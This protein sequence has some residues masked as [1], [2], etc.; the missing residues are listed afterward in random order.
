MCVKVFLLLVLV[1]DWTQC[2]P[3]GVSTPPAMQR[4]RT[5][6]FPKNGWPGLRRG[7]IDWYNLHSPPPDCGAPTTCRLYP[8]GAANW[9]QLIHPGPSSSRSS[10]F[11]ESSPLYVATLTHYSTEPLT[12]GSDYDPLLLLLAVAA[13][14]C[15]R[16][17]ERQGTPA[18]K[19]H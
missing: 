5:A 8:F 9:S 15:T 3:Q 2:L 17:Q 7:G 19:R 12:T 16:T 6:G 14:M 10:Y 1:L 18:S 13:V 11:M 4:G